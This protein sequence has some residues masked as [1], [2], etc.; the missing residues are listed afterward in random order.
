VILKMRPTIRAVHRI[1]ANL[2][3]IRPA[4]IL[5]HPVIPDST[6][7]T[8]GEPEW[9]SNVSNEYTL[10]FHIVS[11]MIVEETTKCGRGQLTSVAGDN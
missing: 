8:S 3:L 1:T 4:C 10:Q 2:T 6:L 11:I 9:C 5:L 7:I